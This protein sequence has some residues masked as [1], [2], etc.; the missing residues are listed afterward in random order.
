MWIYSILLLILQAA[1]DFLRS[2]LAFTP[3]MRAWCMLKPEQCPGHA[4][5]YRSDICF[6]RNFGVGMLQCSKDIITPPTVPNERVF[7]TVGF[8]SNIWV[9]FLVK[10]LKCAVL[11]CTSKSG[12]REVHTFL[13]SRV[14]A[15]LMKPEWDMSFNVLSLINASGWCMSSCDISIKYG[16]ALV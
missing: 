2:K 14:W 10:M 7:N 12:G 5:F 13:L 6:L 3:L 8:M 1:G 16:W 15:K 4:M 9:H 11:R